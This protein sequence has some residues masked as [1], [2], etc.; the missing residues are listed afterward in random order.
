MVIKDS[1]D[2]SQERFLS[3]PISG[4]GNQILKPGNVFLINT[5]GLEIK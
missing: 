2:L 3:F 1:G 4:R 5:T